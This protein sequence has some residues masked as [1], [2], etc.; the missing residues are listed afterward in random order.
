VT[1]GEKPKEQVVAEAR[2]EMIVGSSS[3]GEG[4]FRDTRNSVQ[5]QTWH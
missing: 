4:R 3:G 1:G 5:N 2:L